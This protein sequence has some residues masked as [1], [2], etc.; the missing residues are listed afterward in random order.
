MK[1]PRVQF[2]FVERRRRL[3]RIV[4][5]VV[6]AH[7]IERFC[8]GV[9]DQRVDC[10]PSSSLRSRLIEQKLNARGRN[11]DALIQNPC[12][13]TFKGSAWLERILGVAVEEDVR[14]SGKQTGGEVVHAKL[15]MAAM[16]QNLLAVDDEGLT[17]IAALFR[18]RSL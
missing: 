17:A 11:M 10:G 6:W 12:R 16:N 14:S 3:D 7:G 1:T 8:G 15:A 9:P 18:D 2:R 4:Q 5:P 13:K